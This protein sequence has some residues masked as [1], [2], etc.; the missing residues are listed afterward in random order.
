MRLEI[1]LGTILVVA[2]FAGCASQD[3]ALSID[4][5]KVK[6][7]A[8]RDMCYYNQSIAKTM[9]LSCEDINN[10]NLKTKCVDTIAV[11]LQDYYTCNRHDQVYKRDACEAKV[12]EVRRK[13]R[14]DAA[15]P[16]GST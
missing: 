5:K 7:S 2:A 9:A 1:I 13:A 12:S 6:A 16:T 14:E 15:R 4:C 11:N 3:S 8:D 10:E